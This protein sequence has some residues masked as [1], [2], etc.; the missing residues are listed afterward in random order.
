MQFYEIFTKME[1][2]WV[3]MKYESNYRIAIAFTVMTFDRAIQPRCAT[4][5]SHMTSAVSYR[6]AL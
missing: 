2:A 3:M 6:R 5:R 4:T 1:R